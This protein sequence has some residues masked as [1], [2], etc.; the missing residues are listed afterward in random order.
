MKYTPHNPQKTNNIIHFT[1]LLYV[2]LISAGNNEY[3]LVNTYKTQAQA[4]LSGHRNLGGCPI[5]P[6]CIPSIL[7]YMYK[8]FLY[9]QYIYIFNVYVYIY[10]CVYNLLYRCQYPCES[11]WNHQKKETAAIQV[12][13]FSGMATSAGAVPV[14]SA[15]HG[16]KPGRMAMIWSYTSRIKE[17]FW[18]LAGSWNIWSWNVSCLEL[19]RL[20]HLKCPSKVYPVKWS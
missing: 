5:I 3:L 4:L 1:R 16:N 6:H 14:L 8:L 15:A 7:H 13:L 9:I 11:I 20:K 12:S 18:S 10:I 17:L 19:D 2:Y